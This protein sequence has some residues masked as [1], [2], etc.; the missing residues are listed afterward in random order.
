[1]GKKIDKKVMR[2]YSQKLCNWQKWGED[3]Q[4]G[5]LNYVTPAEIVEAA[6]L[7]KNGKVF[8]LAID[9]GNTGPQVG[10]DGRINPLHTMIATGSDAVLGKH[11]ARK[12]RYADD[13][14]TMPLQSAT[15]WD[16]LGHIF[17]LFDYE[18][19]EREV[20]M[21]NGYSASNV[22]S[23]GLHKCGIENSRTKLV[24]R[25]VL[26]DVARYKG[27]D[28]LP[29]GYGIT[30]EDLDNCCEQFN[31]T[32]KK[33]DFVLIRTGQV[34]ESVKRGN[35]DDFAGGGAPGLAFETLTWIHD[36]E[37]AGLASDTWGVEVRPNNSDEYDQPFHQICLPI[38]GLSHGEIFFLD[39]LADDCAKDGR[40]EFF[41]VSPTI[42]FLGG[43]ASPINPLAI[44]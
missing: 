27:V 23:L 43:S 24:G 13:L 28:N 2:E 17:H 41:Y 14:I 1:M 26:L 11:D 10:L 4:I 38:I 30:I 40:Y 16:A 9:F 18:E 15:H 42:P 19:G 8:S 12:C 7:I 44:K 37:I 31:M 6:G 35:W 29:N 39:D 5:T 34:G 3:D 33:G 21:W 22:D 20:L 36:K 25:G 32:I